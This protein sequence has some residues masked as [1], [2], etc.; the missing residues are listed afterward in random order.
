[1]TE[2]DKPWL[3]RYLGWGE[4][5]AKPGT[6][7]IYYD[8]LAAMRRQPQ[9]YRFLLDRIG[10]ASLAPSY[11]A[12]SVPDQPNCV[13]GVGEYGYYQALFDT[14]GSGDDPVRKEFL[15]LDTGDVP[16]DLAV[17]IGLGP[18]AHLWHQE[19]D[20][21]YLVLRRLHWDRPDAVQRRRPAAFTFPD[22]G[23]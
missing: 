8:A 5:L 19:G 21:L 9:R 18:Y 23:P 22:G 4:D 2:F 16:S 3:A 6:I 15:K 7:S 13:L 10:G 14:A 11:H 17:A 1:M 20:R 12:V